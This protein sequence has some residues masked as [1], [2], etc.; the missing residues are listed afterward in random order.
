M[1]YGFLF[2]LLLLSL[3]A[4][5]FQ[6]DVLT[7]EPSANLDLLSATPRPFPTFTPTT[8]SDS[9][10]PTETPPPYPTSPAPPTITPSPLPRNIGTYPI[11]FAPDG[12]YVDVVDT[13]VAGTS[14]TY[15]VNALKGQ[16]MSISFHQSD[17]GNWTVV[18]LKIVGADGTVLCPQNENTTCYFWR[19]VLPVTQAYFVTLT[20]FIDIQDFTLRVA[21]DPPGTASQSFQY[22]SQSKNASFTYSDEF[23][24]VRFT[25]MHFYKF[26]P[27]AVFQ[28]IDTQSLSGTNLIEAYFIFSASADPALVESC[29]QP[30]DWVTNE[31]VTG[32]VNINDVKFVR[33]TRGGVATGNIYD[34]ISYRTRLN[35][36]CYE[37]RYLIHYADVALFPPEMN[38]REFDRVALLQKLDAILST[39]II[40]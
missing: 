33:N 12:T 20:P 39:L 24:P 8:L 9:A 27:E 22:V 31:V 2:I 13:I 14:K 19:G 16:V 36:V 5:T 11:R 38:V 10:A 1:R 6:V 21:I 17:I 32:E 18:P 37:A 34:E 30:P 29:F 26:E 28:F 4:C 3:S 23:A 25:E 40:K 35:E 15:S 7:P